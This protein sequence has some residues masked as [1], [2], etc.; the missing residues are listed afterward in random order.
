M[1]LRFFIF[2]LFISSFLQQCNQEQTDLF[3]ALKDDKYGYINNEGRVVISP[4]FQE[5]KEFKSG[6]AR[7]RVNDKWGFIN[8]SGEFVIPPKY[9]VIEDFNSNIWI[10]K[11]LAGVILDGKYY[12]IDLKGKIVRQELNYFEGLAKVEFGKKFGFIDT[13]RIFIIEPQFEEA[14]NFSA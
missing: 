8:K 2:I 3:P 5:A 6:L 7:V 1:S 9:N 11:D 14:G 10:D 13:S 12:C 4:Q